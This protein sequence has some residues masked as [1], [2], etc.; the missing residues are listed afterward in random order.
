MA[1]LLLLTNGCHRA[2]VFDY[3]GWRVAHAGSGERGLLFSLFATMAAATAALNLDA[4]V[5][6]MTPVVLA[7]ASRRGIGHEAFS[8]STV[9]LANSASLLMPVS[10]LTNI[11]VFHETD[12]SFGHFTALMALPWLGAIAVERLLVPRLARP[13]EVRSP[14][15]LAT[16]KPEVSVWPAALLGIV[17]SGFIV[18]GPLGVE[19]L[20]IAW[21]GAA[22][23]VLGEL[24]GRTAGPV[25]LVR[26]I[27]PLFLAA[28]LALGGL[29]WLLGDLGLTDLIADLVPAGT[30]FGSLL[31]IAFGAAVL[32][33]L[34]NNIPATLILL[35]AVAPAGEGALLAMLIGV[36]IGPNLAYPGSI[37]NLL[38]RRVMIE[39][40]AAVSWR[41]FTRIGLVTVP[42]GIFVATALLCVVYTGV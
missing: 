4:A 18:S 40:G 33:N 42:T 17:L 30:G 2:G 36:G 20:A 15:E 11:M 10:N 35:P 5:L 3:A 37:A 12:L 13:A 22:V 41:E 34:I 16:V 14:P 25:E 32:A 8:I 27:R 31:L 6:V 29:A 21:A 1:A 26:A 28:L 7:V 38:W 24:A 19:P 39:D 23:M 9:H